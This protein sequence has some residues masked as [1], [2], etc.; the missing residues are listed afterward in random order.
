VNVVDFVR[1]LAMLLI[2]GTLLRVVELNWAGKPGFRGQLA[3]AL[4]VIY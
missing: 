1:F 3:A 2:A 4:G